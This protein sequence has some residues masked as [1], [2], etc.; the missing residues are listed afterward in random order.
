MDRYLQYLA[1][2]VD[3]LVSVYTGSS[4]NALSLVADNDDWATD[5]SDA[6][7]S[8]MWQD[9]TSFLTFQALPNTTYYFRLLDISNRNIN[10]TIT[11]RNRPTMY[12]VRED[13]PPGDYWCF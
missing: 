11:F 9:V 1:G 10:M 4:V 13:T 3:T 5:S 2:R 8:C 12:S 7:W 6:D